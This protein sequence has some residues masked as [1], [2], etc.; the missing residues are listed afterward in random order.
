MEYR[1][2][3]NLGLV[4]GARD[5]GSKFGNNPYG[6]CDCPFPAFAG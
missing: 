4:N 5:F 3:Q 2:P 1:K 6:K